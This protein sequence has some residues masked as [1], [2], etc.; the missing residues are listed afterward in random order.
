MAKK[1]KDRTGSLGFEAKLWEAAD[2]L[3]S[4]RDPAEYKHVVHHGTESTIPN[5]W[6]DGRLGV[7]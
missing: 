4:N 2:H 6:I 7:A 3:R 5:A 1:N